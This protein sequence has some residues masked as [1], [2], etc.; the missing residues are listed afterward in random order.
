MLGKVKARFPGLSQS[1]TNAV[2]CFTPTNTAQGTVDAIETAEA[3][4]SAPLAGTSSQH[5]PSDSEPLKLGSN[6]K[7]EKDSVKV[8]TDN[9]DP[10]PCTE[11]RSL[12]HRVPQGLPADIRLNLAMFSSAI[13]S[14]GQELIKLANE[15]DDGKYERRYLYTA[16]DDSL[17]SCE[18]VLPKHVVSLPKAEAFSSEKVGDIV[19]RAHRFVR[20]QMPLIARL[21]EDPAVAFKDVGY[22]IFKALFGDTQLFPM[23]RGILSHEQEFWKNDECFTDQFL[24]GCNPTVIERPSSLKQVQQSMPIEL[25]TVCDEYGRSVKQIFQAGD[26]YWVDYSVLS[27]SGLA[28]GIDDESGALTNPIYFDVA[29]KMTKYF[30]APFVALYG[31]KEGRLGILGIV[32]TR[33]KNRTNHVYNANTCRETPNIYTFAKMHVSCADNQLHQFY[34]HLGRCHLIYEPFG[35]AVR[36]VFQHGSVDAQDHAVGKLLKPHFH[37]HM[38]INWMARKTLIAHGDDT[39]AFTDAGFALGSTGGVK[40]L[41]AKYRKWNLQDQAFPRQLAT[42]G[43]DPECRDNLERYYYREDG[44]RIW[45]AL[46]QYVGMVLEAF[47]SADSVEKRNA[48]VAEDNVLDEWCAEMRDCNRA[49]VPSFPAKFNDV[50][51]LRETITTIIYSVSA[52]HSAVNASQERYLSYVPNRPNAL[53]RPVPPPGSKRDLDLLR[54]VL[55]IHRMGGNELGAS[56][57]IGF[58]IFQVQFAQLLTMKPTRTLMELD[59]LKYEYREAYERLMRELE[60]THYLIKARNLR[61]EM[62]GEQNFVYEFLDPVQV[63]I[64]VE[65]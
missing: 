57:P 12:N 54:E 36:N 39:I 7:S 53:F 49:F 51:K 22:D 10:I 23:P 8:Q 61:I 17:S 47:Y 25:A 58:A 46:S 33:S 43:F 50:E 38:A 59:D 52:E 64:S 16:F 31:R 35:V 32:L 48:L 18:P 30:Y 28:D 20:S 13:V 56:M 42:R 19:S 40:L 9:E 24:N 4:A 44:M 5:P 60:V 21:D 41:A 62:D 1:F 37:D 11:V 15:W 63:S 27:T 29:P 34:Y 45:K 55:G 2:S 26:L 65:I 14:I 3:S 6:Q